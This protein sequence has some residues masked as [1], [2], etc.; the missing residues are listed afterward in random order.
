MGTLLSYVQVGL[1]NSITFF[2]NNILKIDFALYCIYAISFKKKAQQSKIL[3]NR[4]LNHHLQDFFVLFPIIKNFQSLC[5]SNK[6]TAVE[7]P[8]FQQIVLQT[9]VSVRLNWKQK[10]K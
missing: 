3:T 7:A 8:D 5:H 2:S 9:D 1:I 4:W 10:E 6:T